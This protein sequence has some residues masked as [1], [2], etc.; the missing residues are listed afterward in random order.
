MKPKRIVRRKETCGR[1]GCGKTKFGE[2]YEFH[3]PADPFVPNTEIPRLKPLHL[4]PRNVGF[5]ES[6]IDALIDALA[7]LRNAPEVGTR[8]THVFLTDAMPRELEQRRELLERRKRLRAIG[9]HDPE[10]K[11]KIDEIERAL[12]ALDRPQK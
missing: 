3:D 8:T 1:L 12:R 2:D 6:E 10:T 11:S 7:E 4:G 9:D 5:V